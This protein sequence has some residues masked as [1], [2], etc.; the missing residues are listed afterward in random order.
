MFGNDESFRNDFSCAS[1]GLFVRLTQR[2]Q[3]MPIFYVIPSVL[4][5]AMEQ[6]NVWWA[7][8]EVILVAS[9][10]CSMLLPG[11]DQAVHIHPLC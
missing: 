7:I 11:Q 9:R 5:P 6:E 10:F 8:R 3:Y 2:G 1:S 4:V